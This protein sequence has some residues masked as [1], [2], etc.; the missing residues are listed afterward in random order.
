M[1]GGIVFSSDYSDRTI[2]MIA[3]GGEDITIIPGKY[4]WESAYTFH[5]VVSE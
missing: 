2:K 5:I 1:N 3:V 4:N